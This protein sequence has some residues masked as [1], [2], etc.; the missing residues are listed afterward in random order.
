MQHNNKNIDDI[1][2]ER[3]GNYTETPP[4][5]E[6]NNIQQQLAGAKPTLTQF[7]LKW[8]NYIFIASLAVG[9]TFY[10]SKKYLTTTPSQEIVVNNNVEKI[11]GTNSSLDNNSTVNETKTNIQ[12]QTGNN[13]TTNK[14]ESKNKNTESK[15]VTENNKKNTANSSTSLHTNN[16]KSQIIASGSIAKRKLNYKNINDIYKNSNVSAT[17][18]NGNGTAIPATEAKVEKGSEVENSIEPNATTD[19]FEKGNSVNIVKNNNE[20]VVNSLVK[21]E[22]VAIETFKKQEKLPLPISKIE[23]TKEEKGI[24]KTPF[25]KWEYGMKIGYEKSDDKNASRSNILAPFMQYNLTKRFSLLIQPGIKSTTVNTKNLQGI[26]SFYKVNKDGHY[27]L[28]DSSLALVIVDSSIVDTF[29]MKK[30]TYY[31]S[32]DSIVKSYSIGGTYL[33]FEL[34]VIMKCKLFKNFSI[35]GGINISFNT[36]VNV[37]ENTYV[38]SN[39]LRTGNYNSVAPHYVTPPSVD[40]IITYDGIPIAD[41]TKPLYTA[42]KGTIITYGYMF[43]INYQLW[44]RYVIDILAQQSSA[45]TN[46]IGGYNINSSFSSFYWRIMVGYKL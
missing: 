32:H 45:K 13:Q 14:V 7:T 20:K 11:T 26:Q 1:F 21:E 34:P 39:I 3:L 17:N 31:Q 15:T 35:M 36:L 22:P 40:K 5:A 27:K 28:T 12:E 25:E 30:Y 16:Q 23:S 8:F 38:G 29:F 24:K 46:V 6:W 41:Y 44:D 4:P 33:C 43:G 37:N 9:V 2:R 18:G 42:P 19:R 10:A